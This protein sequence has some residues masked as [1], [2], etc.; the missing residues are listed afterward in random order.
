[1]KNWFLPGDPTRSLD[2]HNGAITMYRVSD[3]IFQYICV[4][5]SAKLSEKG[6]L[7]LKPLVLKKIHSSPQFH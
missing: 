3:R 5:Q 2:L 6:L 7:M 1:M 4:V